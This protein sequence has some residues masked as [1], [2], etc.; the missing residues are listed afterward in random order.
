MSFD[1]GKPAGMGDQWKAADHVGRL[2]A[3]VEP[4]RTTAPTKFGESDATKCTYI[5]VLDGPDAGTV[6]DGPMIFGNISKDA[7]AEGLHK[8][9]L[10]RVAVGQAKAGQSAPFILNEASEDDTAIA[11]K[12]FDANAKINPAGRVLISA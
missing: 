3:F 2:C 4:S 1:F 8:I 7:Y 9:V 6:Y 12:W 10:G 5:V 11:G